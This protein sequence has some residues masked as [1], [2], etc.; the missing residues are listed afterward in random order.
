[1][2]PTSKAFTDQHRN[3]SLGSSSTGL[4]TRKGRVKNRKENGKETNSIEEEGK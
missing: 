2:N 3:R 4:L 1:V